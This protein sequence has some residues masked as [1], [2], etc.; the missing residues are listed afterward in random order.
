MTKKTQPDGNNR[1]ENKMPAIHPSAIS[2]VRAH[3]MATKAIMD[4]MPAEA[5][6]RITLWQNETDLS[7][8]A[9]AADAVA[10]L[11]AMEAALNH[12]MLKPDHGKAIALSTAIGKATVPRFETQALILQVANNALFSP[13]NGKLMGVIWFNAA[14]EPEGADDVLLT[15]VRTDWRAA[16]ARIRN[17]PDV[18]GHRYMTESDVTHNDAIHNRTDVQVGKKRG[19]GWHGVTY[20]PEAGYQAMLRTTLMEQAGSR[21]IR[22]GRFPNI[23]D[24]PAPEEPRQQR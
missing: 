17:E 18:T 10:K 6:T 9:Q 21:I 14:V 4:A 8:H 22:E 12:M 19:K 7:Q 11:F 24:L 13:K 15:Q 1:K 5:A 3:M 20:D 2:T 16:L 23:E